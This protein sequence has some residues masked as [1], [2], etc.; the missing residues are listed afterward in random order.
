MLEEFEAWVSANQSYLQKKGI[1][2]SIITP[3]IKTDKN[4]IY[5]DIES[6]SYLARVT[7]WESGEYEQEAI[8]ILT[9]ERIWGEYH[10][11]QSPDEVESLLGLFFNKMIQAIG[12]WSTIRYEHPDDAPK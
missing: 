11:L 12:D 4:C 2:V 1:T 3:S 8:D 7:V 6:E 10:Q 5:V 9:E